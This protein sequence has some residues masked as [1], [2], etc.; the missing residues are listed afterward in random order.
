M[1]TRRGAC[2]LA[3]VDIDGTPDEEDAHFVRVYGPWQPLVPE[4]L[5]RMLHGFPHPWWIVGGH[6]MEAFH[7]AGR[8]HED[9]DVSFFPSALTD[10]RRHLGDGYVLWS[11]HGGT[12]RVIDD[13][14][15]EPLDPL[16]QVWVRES[17]LSPWL[18][19]C[20]PS[21]EVEGRWQ[22]KRDES[23]V[24][25]LD[26]VT[27]VDDRG[28]RFLNPEVVLLFKAAAH[29]PKDE[30]DLER[31]WPLLGPEKQA[32]LV[33]AVRRQDAGHPWLGRLSAAG[34]G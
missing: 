27:W 16:A 18:M 12:F 28:I 19:D 3:R 6:A 13:Q 20:V 10:L 4:E 9:L 30:Y 26:D 14:R 25:D 5:Q 7:R 17:A 31:A 34:P 29:R 1:C 23:H 22:S 24:A 8:F 21:P 2:R 32:W 15:P 33:E 11:N